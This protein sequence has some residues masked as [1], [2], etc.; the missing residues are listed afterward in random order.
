MDDVYGMLIDNKLE[1]ES[2]SDEIRRILSKRKTKSLK[3]FYGILT[4]EEGEDILKAL[5][6]KREIEIKSMKER[7]KRFQ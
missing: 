7:V 6:R 1:H 2:F 4:E 5:E 3:D